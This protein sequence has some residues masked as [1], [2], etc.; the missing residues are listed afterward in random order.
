MNNTEI[1]K[2]FLIKKLPENLESYKY[3]II[4]QGYLS[5]EPV[6]RVRRSDDEYYMTYK[7]S[8]MLQRTEYNLPL[9]EESYNHLIKKADGNIISKKRYLIPIENTSLTI[10]LDVF[11][12]PFA[13]LVMAEVE[14]ESLED[15]ENFSLPDWFDKEVTN[16][17]RYH[18][19]N[20]TKMDIKKW[21]Y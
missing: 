6:I 19:S 20:M 5:T 4:E 12:E 16:D 13:P 18:N 17:K 15:A 14:F 2:K 7:G 21:E 3:H 11:S 8:G 10:E 9:T 1:E